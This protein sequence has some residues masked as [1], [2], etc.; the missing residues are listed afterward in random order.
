MIFRDRASRIW[1]WFQSDMAKQ[2]P[3]GEKLTRVPKVQNLPFFSPP[4][5]KFVCQ[6][7]VFQ[8]AR[9]PSTRV[10][11]VVPSGEN[12]TEL[13]KFQFGTPLNSRWG[14]CHWPTSQIRTTAPPFAARYL[15]SG[16]KATP[17]ESIESLKPPT[18]AMICF[19]ARSVISMIRLQPR[20]RRSPRGEI[21]RQLSQSLLSVIE[22]FSCPW[23]NCHRYRH[24]HPSNSRV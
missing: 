15:P 13:L 4:G 19:E 7:V 22:N 17:R 20:A 24:S 2:L 11:K 1:S 16:E 6:V 23:H 8:K 3:S 21:A 5:I 10:T 12:A 9:P 18:V 14:V